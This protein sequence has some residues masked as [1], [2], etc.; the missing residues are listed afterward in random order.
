MFGN[1]SKYYNSNSI[2]KRILYKKEAG[3]SCWFCCHCTAYAKLQYDLIVR[4]TTCYYLVCYHINSL[5]LGFEII[6]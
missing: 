1:I 4:I 2:F 6:L 5:S 3:K